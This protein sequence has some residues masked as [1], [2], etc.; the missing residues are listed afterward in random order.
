MASADDK[1]QRPNPSAPFNA[2]LIGA[3]TF[4]YALMDAKSRVAGIY[5]IILLTLSWRD[6]TK[7][8]S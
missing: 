1:G 4:P 7:I 6:L 8:K 5:L 3:F 2:V